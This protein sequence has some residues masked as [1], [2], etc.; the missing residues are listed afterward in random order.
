MFALKAPI[1][2]FL[3]CGLSLAASPLRGG[4]SLPGYHFETVLSPPGVQTQAYGINERGE[5]AG[6][7]RHASDPIIATI[8]A[9][10]GPHQLGLFGSKVSSAYDVNSSGVVIGQ[11]VQGPL[12][13]RSFRW[14]AGS[15]EIWLSC[16][17]SGSSESGIG[18]EP[19]D[20]P[21]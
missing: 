9:A 11:A 3:L 20:T 15:Y 2:T 14:R 10:N 7:S 6:S 4:P 8:W 17:F 18:H 12:G 1:A 19:R 13:E 16:T 21:C 5:V